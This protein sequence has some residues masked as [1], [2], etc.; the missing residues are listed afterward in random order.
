MNVTV[1]TEKCRSCREL[2]MLRRARPGTRVVDYE[3]LARLVCPVPAG[4]RDVTE[5]PRPADAAPHNIMVAVP[6]APEI[7]MEMFFGLFGQ[8]LAAPIPEFANGVPTDRQ[9]LLALARTFRPRR[10]LEIGVRYGATAHLLLRECP[11]IEE[12]WGVDCGPEY[13]MGISTQHGEHPDCVGHDGLGHT[14]EHA[15]W[16]ER[17]TECGKWVSDPR[18]VLKVLPNGSHDIA[19]DTCGRFDLIFIDGD[20]AYEGVWFD[21]KLA[22]RIVRRPGLICWHDYKRDDPNPGAGGAHRVID[23]LNRRERNRIHRVQGT[24]L[25]FQIAEAPENLLPCSTFRVLA[26]PDSPVQFNSSI[27][28]AGGNGYLVALRRD[29]ALPGSMGLAFLDRRFEPAS[30]TLA[31]WP[32]GEDPR[33]LRAPQTDR[34]WLLHSRLE[35]DVPRVQCAVEIEARYP[36]TIRVVRRTTL[37]GAVDGPRI[38][39]SDLAAGQGAAPQPFY[40]R[41]EPS[42]LAVIEKNWVPF[43]HGDRLRISYGLNPHVVLEIAD[44]DAGLVRPLHATYTERLPIDMKLH[45][46]TPHVYVSELGAYLSMFHTSWDRLRYDPRLFDSGAG[47]YSLGFLLMEPT[48]PFRFTHASR[49]GVLFQDL[50]PKIHYDSSRPLVTGTIFPAGLVVRDGTVAVSY[51]EGDLRTRVAVCGLDD[52]L[53]TLEPIYPTMEEPDVLASL[54][55]DTPGHP[56]A[57]VDRRL[58]RDTLSVP[59]ARRS[60][61]SGAATDVRRART[62]QEAAP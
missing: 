44:W 5:T 50:Y 55:V 20:H 9:C 35:G 15:L 29:Y 51:G 6:P 56:I 39:A 30:D 24:C 23:F 60:P 11:W 54:P 34:Y 41:A 48:P 27:A 37:R 46:S 49:R 25:A 38:K 17:G 28:P 10:V 21:T 12:Y 40:D 45:G 42:P 59:R 43:L 2:R 16:R 7:S 62:L 53:A 61:A 14:Q 31:Q 26:V 13:M 52:V 36:D 3:E 32:N 57:H 8:G 1:A 47:C 22:R 19:P 4:R 33:L 58:Y 18:F